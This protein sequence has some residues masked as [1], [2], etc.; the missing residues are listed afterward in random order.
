[1]FIAKHAVKGL[2]VIII[3]VFLVLCM[4]QEN[5]HAAGT[6]E[7]DIQ[8]LEYTT[9]VGLSVNI[10]VRCQSLT[11]GYY[12]LYKIEQDGEDVYT[13]KIVQSKCIC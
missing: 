5:V 8:P 9:T 12:D 2:A 3:T 11:T 7:W 1:M 4:Q 10:Y 13:G 6:G